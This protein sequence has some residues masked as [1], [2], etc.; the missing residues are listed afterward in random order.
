M[1]S[2]RARPSWQSLCSPGARSRGVQPSIAPSAADGG[3]ELLRPTV[4]RADA[5][6]TPRSRFR[7]DR[8][9]HHEPQVR[10]HLDELVALADGGE[11]L[12]LCGVDVVEPALGTSDA[13][14]RGDEIAT[15][16]EGEQARVA[17]LPPGLVE[18][19]T[20]VLPI[21]GD[22]PFGLFGPNLFGDRKREP[23][24]IRSSVRH[25]R[26]PAL[27]GVAGV[28]RLGDLDPDEHREPVRRPRGRLRGRD[29]GQRLGLGV[30]RWH[31]GL[32]GP[33]G[34]RPAGRGTVL[35]GRACRHGQRRSHGEHPERP[36]SQSPTT[37]VRSCQTRSGH[38]KPARRLFSVPEAV[39]PFWRDTLGLDVIYLA[40]NHLSDKGVDGISSTLRLLEEYGLAG[41]GLG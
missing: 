29:A 35:P 11:L 30:R 34:R 14:V 15:R 31:R 2:T 18:P 19:A 23:R 32:C 17:L 20:R 6:A 33:G 9:R 40:A 16:L 3:A 39:L 5:V 28:R 8:H 41:T 10:H 22:G 36:T 37:N 21:A 12:M 26:R 4:T 24:T 13:C 1:R 25:V 38:H 27:G 7:L